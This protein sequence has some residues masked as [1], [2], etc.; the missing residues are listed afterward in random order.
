MRAINIM[1]PTNTYRIPERPIQRPSDSFRRFGTVYIPENDS[2]MLVPLPA[3]ERLVYSTRPVLD[4][5]QEP[6]EPILQPGF[7]AQHHVLVDTLVGAAFS[8][9]LYE[10]F[11]RR[12]T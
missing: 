2:P 8:W 4:R 6:V 5:P 9:A 12:F 3:E 1:R 7:Y 10:M 11:F